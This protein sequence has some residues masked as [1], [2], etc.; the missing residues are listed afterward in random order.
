MGFSSPKGIVF[1]G[2]PKFES[3]SVSTNGSTQ[4]LFFHQVATGKNRILRRLRVSA[5]IPSDWILEIDGEVKASGHTAPGKPDDLYCW[6][7]GLTVDEDIEIEVKLTQCQANPSVTA[8]AH[9]ESS[10][11]NV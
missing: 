8:R 4:Q 9:L 5:P 10:E 7:Q 11:I 3:G 2:V 1:P 6:D